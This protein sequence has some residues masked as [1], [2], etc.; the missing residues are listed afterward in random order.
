MKIF[1]KVSNNSK[2]SSRHVLVFLSALLV[3]SGLV[4]LG[5]GVSYAR[6][7][8]TEQAEF[9]EDLAEQRIVP[10]NPQGELEPIFEALREK[11]DALLAA[12]RALEARSL[13][14]E[15]KSSKRLA[16]LQDAE[17][18]IAQSL[19]DLEAA[20]QDLAALVSTVDR[21]SQDDV[22]RLIAMYENMKPKD[23]ALL[24]EQMAPD[25]SAGFLGKMRSDKAAAILSGMSAEKAYGVSVV[26]AGR[27]AQRK[28][29]N[30]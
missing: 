11:E 15:E 23:A 29:S 18:R 26:L 27:N 9:T 14:L 30:N 25:F 16:Q 19:K 12:E 4:R 22:D 8:G 6:A 28:V 7:I 24:F 5:G 1:G 3:C 2:T 13:E 17:A 20:E 10:M 21:G